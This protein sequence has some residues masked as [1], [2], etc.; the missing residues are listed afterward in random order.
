VAVPR[1]QEG[2]LSMFT[3][4][5]AVVAKYCLMLAVVGLIAIIACVSLQV[6]GRYVLNDTPTWA[7]ALALVLVIWVTMFGAAVGVRDAGHIGM[8]SLL[9]LVSDKLRYK[10]ELVIHV[11]SGTFGALMAWYGAVL[12]NSVMGYKIPTLGIPE[13]LNQVPV[14][15]AGALILLFSIEHIIA[16][17]K[18]EEVVPSWH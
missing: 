10:L 8:E 2:I 18:G 3:R 14:A 15:I 4:F 16:L 13:G 11:L 12:A 7:E 5:C 17:V 9:V 1:R 6:F